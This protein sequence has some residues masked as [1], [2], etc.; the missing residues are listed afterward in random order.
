MLWTL[1]LMMDINVRR[2]A[3]G[4][5]LILINTHPPGLVWVSLMSWFTPRCCR[6]WRD[7]RSSA[8]LQ[9]EVAPMVTWGWQVGNR[10]MRMY[11]PDLDDR[12]GPCGCKG[13]RRHTR[14]SL[15]R[16][17]A[18]RWTNASMPRASWSTAGSHKG[19]CPTGWRPGKWIEYF[20]VLGCFR[21]KFTTLNKQFS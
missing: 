8:A 1:P 9:C 18:E 6:S 14:A 2:A 15:R 19:C 20:I 11:A 17:P 12:G 4:E 13:L 10:Q 7:S 16:I 3:I 5:D 21:Y